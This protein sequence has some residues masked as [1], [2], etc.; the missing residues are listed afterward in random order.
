MANKFRQQVHQEVMHQEEVH[1]LKL[2]H[3]VKITWLPNTATTSL[4]QR[5]YGHQIWMPIKPLMPGGIVTHT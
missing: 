1:H 2:V 3:H 5:F 4:K